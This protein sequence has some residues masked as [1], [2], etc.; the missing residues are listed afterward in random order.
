MHAAFLIVAGTGR[1]RMGAGLSG[2]F[3]GMSLLLW[4]VLLYLMG[5]VLFSI[6]LA[7]LLGA[8]GRK[9]AFCII[10]GVYFFFGGLCFGRCL[11]CELV[12]QFFSCYFYLVVFWYV[13]YL[14]VL[15][16]SYSDFASE[17]FGQSFA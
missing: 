13:E 10:Y 2:Y 14:I 7:L 16:V 15:G 12:V 11:E 6:K 1:A 4:L 5:R 8:F 17:L 9:K 3:S